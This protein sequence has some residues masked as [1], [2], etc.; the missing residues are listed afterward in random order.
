MWHRYLSRVIIFPA[1]FTDRLLLLRLFRNAGFREPARLERHVREI[2]PRSSFLHTLYLHRLAL[3]LTALFLSFSPSRL[4]SPLYF[5]S[6][7]TPPFSTHTHFPLSSVG[8]LLI[9][10]SSQMTMERVQKENPNVTDGG[11]YTPPDCR[12]RWKVCMH[13]RGVKQANCAG[14]PLL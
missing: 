10:F 12:P 8:R 11:R 5:L 9:E 7:F 1:L 13:A 14:N 2:P 4:P 3:K 6:S